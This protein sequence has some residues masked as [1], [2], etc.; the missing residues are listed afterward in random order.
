MIY[1]YIKTIF[2]FFIRKSQQGDTGYNNQLRNNFYKKFFTGVFSLFFLFSVLGEP[3]AMNNGENEGNDSRQ[4]SLRGHSLRSTQSYGSESQGNESRE[5][6]TPD[7]HSEALFA[8]FLRAHGG[9]TLE[10]VSS[11]FSCPCFGPAKRCC[12]SVFG[13]S[14]CMFTCIFSSIGGLGGAGVGFCRELLLSS[15]MNKI[16]PTAIIPT[17]TTTV[18]SVPIASIAYGMACCIICGSLGCT[19]SFCT[20]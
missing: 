12:K 1:L 20:K 16:P 6:P 7:P 11:G 18:F 10:D 5:S 2:Y 14:C 9:D 4:P 15:A 8:A 17:A 19:C 13:K 3:F